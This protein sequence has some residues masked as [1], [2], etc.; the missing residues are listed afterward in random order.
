MCPRLSVEDT[1]V[2]YTHVLI[3]AAFL[4]AALALAPL[5]RTQ[6]DGIRPYYWPN[7]T[8]GIPVAN[9]DQL[10]KAPNRPSEVQL[11]YSLNRGQLQKGPKLP[12]TG[13]KPLDAGQSGF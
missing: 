11:Y 7:R 8:V 4:G 13:M 1:T 12:L 2:R 3:T 9:A 10:L 5:A 6:D